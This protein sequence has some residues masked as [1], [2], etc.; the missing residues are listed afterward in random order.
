MAYTTSVARETIFMKFL[1]R[2]SRA[3]APKIRV[4]FGLFSGS[5]I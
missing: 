4:P 2:S 3:T 5:M 1:S